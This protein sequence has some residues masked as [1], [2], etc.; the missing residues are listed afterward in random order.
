MRTAGDPFMDMEIIVR[1]VEQPARLR[2]FAEDKL[3]R[4][5]HRFDE[6]V[7]TATMRLEDVTGPEK[8]RGVDKQCSIE[9]RL[10]TG[11][12]RITEQGDDFEATVN[13][14]IDRLKSAISREVAKA[15]RGV[16]EG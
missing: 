15:K 6:R 7:L 1:G 5:L 13:T 8:K 2:E 16:G 10:R 14:A 4:A 3:M 12:V 11:E 9:I